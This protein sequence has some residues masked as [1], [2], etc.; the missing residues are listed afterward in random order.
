MRGQ[1][2]IVGGI[3]CA[4]LVFISMITAQW[5]NREVGINMLHVSMGGSGLYIVYLMVL[6]YKNRNKK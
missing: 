1:N 2:M 6:G 4:A 3:V 5:I